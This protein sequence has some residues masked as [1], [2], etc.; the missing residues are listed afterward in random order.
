LSTLQFQSLSVDP[1]H[2]QNGLMGGTQDNGTFEYGG[3][4]QVWPQII[5]G[6]GGQSGWN[7][8]DSNLRF[9][10]FT[11]QASDVNFRNG[12]P[13]AWVIATGPIAASPEG[14]YFYPPV[15]AD[16]NPATAGSIFQGSQ[17]VWRT[18]DWG[19]NQAYLEANCPEFT[20][21]FNNP[22]C[23]DFVRIGGA[24]S[25]LG[26]AF[27]GDRAC[28]LPAA[29]TG[30]FVAAIERA[31]SNTGT[32]WA[33]TGTGRLFISDNGNDPSASSV[34]W[35]RLDSLAT[36]DPNRFIS[37]IYVDPNY[38][39]LVQKGSGVPVPLSPNGGYSLDS[40]DPVIT[41]GLTQCGANGVPDSCMTNDLFHPSPRVGIPVS[42][43]CL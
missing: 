37:S 19:G 8:A 35:N 40:L 25:D 1:R 6:D 15:T 36:N 41:N 21:A 14:P 38:G 39:Y 12:D 33:A 13:T 3:S 11:G 42:S 17:S 32:L 18:Q 43:E 23:G 9:N 34:V 7:A 5:Y 16:P 27:W 22:A 4:S 29:T 28:Q 26:S 31:P 24:N 2:P 10:T 30:C 20:T